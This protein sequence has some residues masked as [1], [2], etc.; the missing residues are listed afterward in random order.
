MVPRATKRRITDSLAGASSDCVDAW[1][2]GKPTSDGA[3]ESAKVS[4]IWPW[5]ISL[6]LLELFSCIVI[7]MKVSGYRF[8]KHVYRENVA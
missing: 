2:G 5:P 8:A 1:S 6:S 3:V 4:G 7:F